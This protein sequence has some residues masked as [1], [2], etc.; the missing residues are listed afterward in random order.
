MDAPATP[1]I[2]AVMIFFNAERYF[3]EAIE[4]VLAQTY[5]NWELMLV[6]DGSTDASTA[7]A[8]DY[9]ARFPDRVRYVEH[10][11]HA[12]R[13]M[14]ASRNAGVAAGRGD[15]VAF[16][17]SDDVWL[18]G[19]MEHFAAVAQR[20]PDAGMI[21]GPTRYWYSWREGADQPKDYTDVLGFPTNELVAAPA[22]LRRLLTDG[23]QPPCICSML[24][25]AD[26]YR[27]VGGFEQSFKGLYEDQVFVSKITFN[28]N[29]VV[30]DEILAL[31]RQHDDS[32]CHQGLKSGDYH[33]EDYHPTRARVLGWLAHYLDAKPGADP[34]IVASVREQLRP[35]QIPLYTTASNI[36]RRYRRRILHVREQ[37]RVHPRAQPAR[38][39]WLA[40]KRIVLRRA[41]EPAA[42][43]VN[44]ATPPG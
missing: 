44:P 34:D 20:F 18:P 24:I 6:D 39:A 4:S 25:R 2:T 22:A 40:F 23:T 43:P 31:Y 13:G 26:A 1:M 3:A 41:P 12:N 38:Q 28:Y 8:R 7:I 35:Y 17:D 27:D 10:P 21:Y 14:S 9:A 33:P 5:A 37:L 16:L 30:I 11:G 19:W 36:R 32:C 42:R 29:I 15:Y